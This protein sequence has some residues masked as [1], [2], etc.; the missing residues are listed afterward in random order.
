MKGVRANYTNGWCPNQPHERIVSAPTTRMDGLR[1]N[2]SKEWCLS[3][4]VVDVSALIFRSAFQPLLHF[5]VMPRQVLD[6]DNKSGGT[7]TMRTRFKDWISIV[8]AGYDI[9]G[10]DQQWIEKLYD[11][12][13]SQLTRGIWP[14]MMTY[15]YS[16]TE[17]N[18]ECCA[19]NGPQKLL[20][21][22]RKSTNQPQEALDLMYRSSIAVGSLSEVVFSRLPELRHVVRKMTFGVMS[23]ILAVKAH[24]GNGRGVLL[25]TGFMGSTSATRTELARWPLVVS[26]LGAGLRLRQFV[27]KLNLDELDHT[28]NPIEAVL[29]PS[30][31]IQHVTVCT[32]NE[33]TC[34]QLRDAALIVERIRNGKSRDEP[35]KTLPLWHAL[36]A[37]RWSLVDRFDSDGKRFIVAVKNDPDHLDPRGL[38]TRERQVAEYVG[39]GFGN[40]AIAYTLG[41]TPTAVSNH[42]ARVLYKLGLHRRVEL[43]SF[44]APGGLRARLAAVSVDEEK[45]LMGSYPLAGS[46]QIDKLTDAE[47][48]VLA[49]LAAGSTNEDIAQRRHTSSRTV[50]NQVQSIFRKLEVRSR[51]ELA[52]NLYCRG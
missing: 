37:G 52:A 21:W 49:H 7:L 51:S 22:A 25:W 43:A 6:I 35:E 20:D 48:V 34:N 13:L 4:T 8:E 11:K 40:K 5:R 2:Y 42:I 18:I 12:S 50:A 46:L 38:T 39:I 29:D 3:H 9:T 31:K 26:H 16:P 32:N 33:N 24:T 23:D 1:A 27:Q 19:I 41:I 10:T 47:R 28:G 45:L 14:G 36:I 17:V 15:R 44:F 30:G